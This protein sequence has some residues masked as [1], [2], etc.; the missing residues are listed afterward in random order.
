MPIIGIMASANWASAN[1]SSFESIA[2]V[3]GSGSSG[4]ISFTSIP[5][6]YK[7]LQI[8]Y[9]AKSTQ[10][11]SAARYSFKGKF[12]SDGTGNY[13]SH[14]LYG[15]GTTVTAAS[16]AT[17][18]LFFTPYQNV[19]PNSA[20][21]YANMHGV[22]IIDIIDYTSTSKAKTIRGMNGEDINGIGGTINLWSGLW[23]A[24]PAAI[25]QIDLT[26][27][28]GSWTTTSSFALYGVK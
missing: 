28:T 11:G 18:E 8:R 21:A 7:A 22:G 5:S 9:I 15:N 1:A 2:T 13:V 4:T 3:T 19:I 16:S 17:S 10:G 23:F 27:D 6:G 26:V 14:A 24:T 12:N 20:T 25:T